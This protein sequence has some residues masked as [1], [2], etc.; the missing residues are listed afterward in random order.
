MIPSKQHFHL[1]AENLPATP[2]SEHSKPINHAYIAGIGHY[3]PNLVHSNQQAETELNLQTGWIEQRTGFSARRYCRADQACTDLAIEAGKNA[4]ANSGIHCSEIGTVLL[5]TSTPDHPLPGS[6]PRIAAQLGITAPAMDLMAACTGF[7]YGL[8]LAN[9]L[10]ST[11]GRPVLLIA[12]NV[13]SRRVNRKDPQT[14]GLFGDGAGALVLS[15][16]ATPKNNFEAKRSGVGHSGVLASDWQS[17]GKN[18]QQL[19][20]PAGGSRRT[21]SP[22]AWAEDAMYMKMESGRAVFKLAVESM[23]ACSQK[24]LSE[25]GTSSDDIDW[26]IPHQASHRIVLEL[27]RRLSIAADRQAWWLGSLGNSSA[28]TIPIALSLGIA[29]QKIIRGHRLLL[30]AA[31]AGMCSSAVLIKY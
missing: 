29:S 20:I 18:W 1:K 23:Q 9:S 4:L 24:V 3:V 8:I 19:L 27:G 16:N 5:A 25:T 30:A 26:L 17:D 28:A 12:S 21:L 10:V 11:L 31:G 14:I 6:A 15:P 7:L 13:L 2:P 22:D